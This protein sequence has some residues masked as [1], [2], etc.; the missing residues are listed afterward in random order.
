MS[1][2]GIH[3]DTTPLNTPSHSINRW[4]WV[5]H[6]KRWRVLGCPIWKTYLMYVVPLVVIFLTAD[7]TTFFR[8]TMTSV[9]KR[10]TLKMGMM[11]R[12]E[13]GMDEEMIEAEKI[14]RE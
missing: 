14:R 8:W 1:S 5:K 13:E 7:G 9:K 6:R 12:R 3:V 10:K 2:D 4:S 11:K